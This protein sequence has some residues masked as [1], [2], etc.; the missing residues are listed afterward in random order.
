MDKVAIIKRQNKRQTFFL[1]FF[2]SNKS[3]L[4]FIVK[5]QT[6]SDIKYQGQASESPQLIVKIKKK[7]THL[8]LVVVH[9]M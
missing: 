4:C 8:D 9:R 3:K 7:S 5:S 6:V 2:S 1:F